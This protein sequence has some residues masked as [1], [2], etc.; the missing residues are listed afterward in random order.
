MASKASPI[1]GDNMFGS[2]VKKLKR[3]LVTVNPFSDAANAP[4]KLPKDILECLEL[5][6]GQEL[7]IPNQVHLYEQQLL[8]FYGAKGD[9]TINAL[10][11]PSFSWTCLKLGLLRQITEGDDEIKQ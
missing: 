6:E 2:R 9:F 5:R 3:I 8:K 7:V 11:P 1:L 4:P 10:P